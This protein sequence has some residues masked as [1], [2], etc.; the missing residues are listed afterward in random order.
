MVLEQLVGGVGGL[1]EDA[2]NG[3][4]LGSVDLEVPC[5]RG[6][7]L[8]VRGD[9]DAASADLEIDLD[10][11]GVSSAGEDDA[12]E[13]T[14]TGPFTYVGYAGERLAVDYHA[15]SLNIRGDLSAQGET[16]AID[17]ACAVSVYVSRT[18]VSWSLAARLCDRDVTLSLS[19]PECS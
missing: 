14:F 12:A 6:G 2:V 3:Q 19:H 4:P 5:P 8:H 18:E 11:C 13:L 10:G 17:V 15:S 1:V 7:A 9:A 16:A